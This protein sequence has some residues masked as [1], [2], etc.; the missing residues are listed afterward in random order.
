MNRTT[1]VFLRDLTTGWVSRVSVS[2][3]GR[4]G[5]LRSFRPS[6]SDNGRYV[7]FLSWASTF[8]PKDI[9]VCPDEPDVTSWCQDAFVHDTKTRN[10]VRVSVSS[11]GAPANQGSASV[12]ISGDG[13]VA[14]FNTSASNLVPD[15]TPGCMDQYQDPCFDAFAHDL[16]AGRTERVS[17]DENGDEFPNGIAAPPVI[18][19]DGS[20][21]AF[22]AF[23]DTTPPGSEGV[24]GYGS[25]YVR[26][27]RKRTT[28]VLPRELGSSPLRISDDGRTVVTMDGSGRTPSILTYD[29][30]TGSVSSILDSS[31]VSGEIRVV[32]VT[33]NTRFLL[34]E[35]GPTSGSEP[36]PPAK[37]LLF[38]A[39]RHRVRT[40]TRLKQDTSFGPFSS[41]Q[42]LSS[43]ARLIVFMSDAADLVRGDTNET[44]DILL[45]DGATK[46][47]WRVSES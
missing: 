29:R 13:H 16:K 28:V 40:I 7:A 14:V 45:W 42:A 5:D 8:V 33:P 15:P 47:F 44:W 43:D 27:R 17:I 35:I 30:A 10:T 36:I 3:T 34:L 41:T 24:T 19:R 32:S 25:V 37:L 23:V 38:D 20:V 39:K 11:S 12:D 22:P 4:E 46:T 18:S 2:S 6:I 21:V 26:D 9:R 1:D 31:D